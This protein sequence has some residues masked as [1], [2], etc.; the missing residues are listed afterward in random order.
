MR[1]EFLF[2]KYAL[3]NETPVLSRSCP[4]MTVDERCNEVLSLVDALGGADLVVTIHAPV[5][6]GACTFSHY[7]IFDDLTN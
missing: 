5:S 6:E 7:E 3:S 2:V 1:V 4:S